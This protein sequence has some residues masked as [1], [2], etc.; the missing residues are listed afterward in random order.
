MIVT[1]YGK[2]IEPGDVIVCQGMRVTVG[3]T[4]YCNDYWKEKDGSDNHYCEFLDVN[5]NYHYW[6]Q[7]LDG[8][9][10]IPKDKVGAA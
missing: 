10:V 5:G 9:Y 6:K 4:I 3:N 1:E 2:Q 7:E 8:G